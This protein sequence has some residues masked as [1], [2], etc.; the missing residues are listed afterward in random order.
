[1]TPKYG[2][3]ELALPGPKEGNPFLEVDL[4]ARFSGGGREFTV[5]GFYDGEGVYKVRFSPEAEGEWRYVTACNV[6]ELDGISGS[7]A[8][9]AAEEG[10]HGPVQVAERF[11]FSHADGTR[12]IP[13]G[14]TAYAWTSQDDETCEMTIDTLSKAPFN[15]IRMSPFPK[16]YLYNHNEPPCYPFEGGLRP[17]MTAEAAVEQAGADFASSVSPAYEFDFDRP[18]P[19]F[20]RRFEGYLERLGKMGIQADLILFHPYDRWGFSQMGRERS[21]NYLR[22][23]VARLGAY[24]NIWWSMANEYDLFF[25]WT[26]EDWEA[27]AAQVV[28]WDAA[29]HL[30]SIHNCLKFY[31]HS[32]PWITHCSIQRIAYHSHAEL[33][34]QWREQYG[35]PVA[36]DEICYEGDI[37]CGWGNITA[38]EMVKRFWDVMTRGGY[39][40]HGETYLRDDDLLWWAKGG[41][42]TG[43]SPAR[44][45]FLRQIMEEA[46][47]F[48]DPKEPP[49]WDVSWGYA[50][51]RFEEEGNIAFRGRG[52]VPY[53]QWML[54]YFSF[55]RPSFR[56][57]NLPQG[58]KYRIDV[59]DTWNMTV[60][61]VEGL[62]GGRTRV[63][64]PARPYM[65]V[66]FV[67]E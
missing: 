50:G 19:V 26:E 4:T 28:K 58:R 63:E 53:A 64:L 43:E 35:K 36:V 30:R 52:Q 49:E 20:W 34:A 24:S 10:S 55:A 57:F 22:Y 38:E 54:C 18:N 7:F 33:T 62:H 60:T 3:F 59:I 40:T 61:P 23:V 16:H 48:V 67:A 56:I 25:T 29:N 13:V 27:C 37:D 6:P 65:A 46:P 47:G 17:G 66:R 31:D 8:C 21:L 2:I 44:I 12:F 15:K 45:A 51:E 11:H 32:R 39:C 5:S 42:L 9:G 41:E 1:M 14:T